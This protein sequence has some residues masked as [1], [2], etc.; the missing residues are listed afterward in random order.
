MAP[1]LGS[2][3]KIFN[4][5]AEISKAPNTY[6]LFTGT[7]SQIPPLMDADQ[8]QFGHA[9]LLG[10]FWEIMDHEPAFQIKYMNLYQ[11]DIFSVANPHFSG[12]LKFY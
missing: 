12:Y 7:V 2:P 1:H 11:K 9:Q 3:L 6:H 10:S 8:S 5:C 4:S